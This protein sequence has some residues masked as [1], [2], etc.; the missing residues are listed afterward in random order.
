MATFCCDVAF[1]V[2]VTM[3]FSV[4]LMT[5][6]PAELGVRPTMVSCGA[7]LPTET[8]TIINQMLE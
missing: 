2:N 8:N 5:Y 7:K 6:C 4:A 1:S 3:V